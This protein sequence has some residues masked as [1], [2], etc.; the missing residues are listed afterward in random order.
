[1]IFIPALML[2]VLLLLNSC[3]TTNFSYC[4]MFPIGGKE[5][6]KELE[7]AGELPNTWE[8]IGRLYKLKQEL[9]ICKT[10]TAP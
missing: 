7:K 4:P 10:P 9:D 5:V 2:L 3:K 1:M 8:W 6:A